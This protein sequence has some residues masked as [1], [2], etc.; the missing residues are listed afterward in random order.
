IQ[1]SI[2]ATMTHN[3]VGQEVRETIKRVKGVL[4]EEQPTP[5][6]SI[7][8]VQREQLKKLRAQKTLMLDE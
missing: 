3:Q 6:K 4:P 1:G 8:E 2:N 7:E 5:S